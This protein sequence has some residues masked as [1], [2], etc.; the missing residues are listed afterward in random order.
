MN[1]NCRNTHGHDLKINAII[2][3]LGVLVGAGTFYLFLD[4][5]KINDKLASIENSLG[6]IT[7]CLD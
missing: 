2:L 3:L 5:L 4:L 7:I 6:G 1:G